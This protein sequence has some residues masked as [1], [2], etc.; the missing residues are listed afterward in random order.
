MANVDFMIDLQLRVNDLMSLQ[1]DVQSLERVPT[2]LDATFG[3]KVSAIQ[4]A[5][6]FIDI[7]NSTGLIS[8]NK[9]LVLASILKAFHY[10]CIKTIK[11]NL[12]EVRSF[13]G[14]GNLAIFAEQSCCDNAVS[15][16]F[17]IK[18]YLGHILKSKQGNAI[19]LD[20]GI[21]I[22]Y[23]TILV[24]KVGSPGEFNNDLI[25]IGSPINKSA[26]MGNR[27][28]SPNN[29]YISD[30]VLRKLCDYNKYIIDSTLGRILLNPY[31]GTKKDIWNR[32]LEPL[33]YVSESAPY[34][35]SYERP[36]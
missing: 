5:C 10:I 22:D 2:K 6:L 14:D 31:I 20:F 26:N 9:P 16:A 8:N 19:N 32:Q 15:S 7:R 24:A 17:A 27:A 4:A 33:F 23:G 36:L 29:I 12:G 28:K 3:E 11:E 34:Y 13:N 21:G 35:S 1:H 18:Y 25:W 30:K